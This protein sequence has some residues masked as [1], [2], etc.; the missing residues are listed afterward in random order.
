MTLILDLPPEVESRLRGEA[1]RNGQ[2]AEEYVLRLIDQSLPE[3]L[4][5]KQHALIAMLDAWDK[6]DE[7]DDPAEVAARRWTGRNSRKR[8]IATMKA[9]G[10]ST[11]EPSNHSRFWIAGISHHPVT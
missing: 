9:L 4:T 11:H 8:S 10:S 2:P 6:E 1:E 5:E 7:T 3:K